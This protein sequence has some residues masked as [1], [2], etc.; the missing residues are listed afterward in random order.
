MVPIPERIRLIVYRPAGSGSLPYPIDATRGKVGRYG[1]CSMLVYCVHL[2]YMGSERGNEGK[3]HV[4]QHPG[5]NIR[6]EEKGNVA[7]RAEIPVLS[8]SARHHRS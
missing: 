1:T 3:I 2:M 7:P 4:S 8:S 6:F 5:Y